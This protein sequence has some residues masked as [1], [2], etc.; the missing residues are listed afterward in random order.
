MASKQ[1]PKRKG[2]DQKPNDAIN[3]KGHRFAI[4]GLNREH[5]P[6]LNFLPCQ[7]APWAGVKPKTEPAIHNAGN[8]RRYCCSRNLSQSSEREPIPGAGQIALCGER[9]LTLYVNWIL[10][11]IPAEKL[12]QFSINKRFSKHSV[13]ND[14]KR[15]NGVQIILSVALELI[16]ATPSKIKKSK[17]RDRARHPPHDQWH[18]TAALMLRNVMFPA[19]GQPASEERNHPK[20]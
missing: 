7:F 12:D 18:S 3:L 5:S 8:A 10:N 9:G 20:G 17:V 6:P 15:S 2:Y 11:P 19:D 13:I 4:A 14:C 16:D 1:R